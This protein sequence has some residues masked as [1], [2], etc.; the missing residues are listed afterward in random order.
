VAAGRENV[1]EDHGSTAAFAEAGS[2]SGRAIPSIEA[3]RM[4]IDDALVRCH[5]RR[6]DVRAHATRRECWALRGRALA[7]SAGYA[8]SA[9]DDRVDDRR[10]APAGGHGAARIRV[11]RDPHDRP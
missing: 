10:A 9:A 7:A 6:Y 5:E 11:V 3:V 4:T 8:T 2:G 1:A